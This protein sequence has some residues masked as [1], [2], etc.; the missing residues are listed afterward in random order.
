MDNLPYDIIEI[1]YQKLHKLYMNDLH[2]EIYQSANDF[3]ERYYELL[4]D[5]DWEPS[6]SDDDEDD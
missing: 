2:F 1:V 4:D 6:E 3:E 5:P